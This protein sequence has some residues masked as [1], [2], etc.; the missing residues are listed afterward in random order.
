MKVS[1]QRT[2]R[3]HTCATN[4]QQ[5]IFVEC[6]I[7]EIGKIA[8]AKDMVHVSILCF[9]YVKLIFYENVRFKVCSLYLSECFNSLLL[10]HNIVCLGVFLLMIV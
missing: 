3:E 10:Q 4:K 8:C 1:A 6:N 9:Q 5:W 2:H 7:L